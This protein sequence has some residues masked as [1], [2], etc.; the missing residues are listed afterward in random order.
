MTRTRAACVAVSSNGSGLATAACHFEGES[1]V[2]GSVPPAK[3]LLGLSFV[4]ATPT[5]LD[6]GD[7]GCPAMRSSALTR[8]PRRLGPFVERAARPVG[9][10]TSDDVEQ[11]GSADLDDLGRPPL[12][13]ERALMGK[14]RLIRP[15]SVDGAELVAT[16]AAGHGTFMA[17]P[18][19]STQSSDQDFDVHRR[20]R[21]ST[22]VRIFLLPS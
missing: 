15:D 8:S 4:N 20:L 2:A 7:V 3:D 13:S 19:P 16:P 11:Q 5:T 6:Y 17:H 10:V 14:Q 12:T 18:P 22:N 1:L 9:V 21:T